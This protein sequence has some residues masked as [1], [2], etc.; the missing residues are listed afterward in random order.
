[1]RALKPFVILALL[2]SVALGVAGCE[3]DSASPAPAS[4]QPTGELADIQSTFD[5]IDADIAGDNSP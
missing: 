3:K 4:S 5:N 1:M 2:G